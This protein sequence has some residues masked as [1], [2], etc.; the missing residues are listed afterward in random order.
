MDPLDTRTRSGTEYPAVRTWGTGVCGIDV[1][2]YVLV[3]YDGGRC[4]LVVSATC[5][6]LRGIGVGVVV[7]EY[8]GGGGNEG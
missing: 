3:E 4:A 6:Q 7:G 5:G 2:V 8:G 1:D